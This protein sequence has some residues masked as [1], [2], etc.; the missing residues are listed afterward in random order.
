MRF[1]QYTQEEMFAVV[2]N[3]AVKSVNKGVI[4]TFRR[5]LSYLKSTS[6]Q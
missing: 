6:F 1:C 5:L 3:V 2:T 4:P